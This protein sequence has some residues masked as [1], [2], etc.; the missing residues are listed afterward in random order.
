MGKGS[1]ST[2]G[3]DR[4][5]TGGDEVKSAYEAMFREADDAIF[6]VDV[7][8]T[9]GEY[10]FTFKQNNAAYQ[11]QTGLTEDAMFG[12]TP[13][14]LLG[15]EQ[16]AAVE[17]NYRRCVERG[18]TIEYE[19]RLDFPGGTS[20]WQT[21]LTPVTDDGE[22]TQLVGVAR[23][24]TEQKERDR[25]YRRT[26][27][28]FRTVL[29]T[30]SAAV[31]LKDTEGR[32]LLMN[33]ACRDLF[34][35]DGDPVGM[36]D[37]DLFPEVV[38]AEAR[39]DDR[40]VVEDGERIEIEETIP[41]A[42]GESVRLTRKSPVYD[43]AGE[44]R[45]VCG[46][47]TDITERRERERALQRI[48]DRLELAVEGA[49]IG[50]WDWDMRTDEVEFNDQWARM[51]GH[52]TD[53]I[54]P[55]IDAWER[56][57]HPEDLGSVEDALSSHVAGE[58]EF[59]DTEH[60]MRTAAGEW[61]WIR[62]VG[63][64]VERDG[65]GEPVRAVGIHLDVDEQKRR[66][67]ELMRTRRVI[68]RTQES[69]S[70]GWW[71]VD[72][73]EESLTWSDEVYRIHEVPTDESVE[74]GDGVAFYH[75]DDRETIEA[76]FDRLIED[77]ESYDLELRIMTETDRTRWVRT[78]GDPQYDENGEI[79]G[80]LGLFQDITERKEYERAIESTREELRKIIDLVPDLVFAK[81]REGEYLLAN[82]ATAAA[83]GRTPADV[84]GKSEGEIIPDADDS[85]EFRQDDVEVIESGEPKTIGEE[86]L[87]TAA[88]ETRILQTT[89]IPYE[90]SETG[91]D[92][93]LGYARDVTELKRYE[94]TLEEQRDTLMLLNQVVRHD[95]RN[96]LM[97]VESY[98]GLLEDSLTDEQS[99]TYART[100]IEAAKQAADIT[101][102][103][104][105]V[106][107]VL[108]QVGV[109]Q[110][111]MRIQTE[112]NRQIEQVRA[113]QDRA[114]VAVEGAIPDA[115]VMADDLLEA[116]F[117]NL[118]TNA[119]VHNDKEVA[120]ITVSAEATDGAVRV[121]IADNGP[122]I[123]D[124]HKEQIF[125]EGEKGLETGGTGIGLYLVK[126]LVDK[127]DGDV[128]VE[129]NEPTGSVFVVE[130]RRAD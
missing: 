21:K 97:V 30:M 25:E 94:R 120:E 45:G 72:L 20:D 65:E 67:A 19:E 123:A 122:G 121:S 11:R 76:A 33:Q 84:E 4:F 127:Y 50:V 35:V 12:K 81:N 69:A 61:K 73:T 42:A 126:T 92:A 113:D 80:A 125:Q 13:R 56:R 17:A 98:T 118:L 90:L 48:K 18:T 15:E 16:G 55:H 37:A 106:T 70:I 29:E 105:D 95:I 108:L 7:A 1:Q 2:G 100:V 77:G 60:R 40:R 102:T 110:T 5:E 114:T 58:T 43:E 91:E 109:E 49:Q 57:V 44:I 74:I 47:S 6:L 101:E 111:P 66:E 103:A 104:K 86:T 89:K 129:D 116:V 107:D 34:D 82:E 99:R 78:V 115:T 83:Y 52:S 53:E 96:Q 39:A 87:T 85:A 3:A 27:R 117:R 124:D 119:V 14:E 38:A 64:V 23:D 36:T 9:D 93:V 62:S 32:Y 88:G 54:E 28:R 26:H 24:I 71:E 112:L 31:F 10:T 22:V 41:T 68:E 130:L 51:L 8:R 46:V 59:Y 79:V 75:P 63:K 128:W